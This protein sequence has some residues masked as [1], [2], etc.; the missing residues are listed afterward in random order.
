MF[1]VLTT[2]CKVWLHLQLFVAK[3][4][5]RASIAKEI[6]HR[7]MMN[8][9]TRQGSLVAKKP[10]A[11]L[12]LCFRTKKS[13]DWTLCTNTNRRY[14]CMHVTM[15]ATLKIATK[16]R[17]C[18]LRFPTASLTITFVLKSRKTLY[19]KNCYWQIPKTFR[20]GSTSAWQFLRQ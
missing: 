8:C 3:S 1:S 14:R 15:D 12:L 17:F 9:G 10:L 2:T 5:A 4:F 19:Q 11:Q 18:W 6:I 13:C 7:N 16:N 20:V